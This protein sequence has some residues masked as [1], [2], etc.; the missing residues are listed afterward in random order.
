MPEGYIMV[1]RD[2][3]YELIDELPERLLPEAER[4]RV[5]LRDGVA[6]DA[7]EDDEPLQPET[8]A[9]IAESRAAYER[10]EGISTA[11]LLERLGLP[12]LGRPDP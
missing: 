10:G 2:A 11:E 7:D 8:E 5:A 12:P 4:Y 6:T 9:M 3:L 1:G